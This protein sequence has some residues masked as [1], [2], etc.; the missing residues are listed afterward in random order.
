M[1]LSAYLDRI[2][3]T[4]TP[5]PDRESLKA[6]HRAHHL[7]VPYDALDVQLE[8]AVST[9][10]AFAYEKIVGQRRGGW[11]YEMNGVFG[12]ALGEIGF[13]VTRIAAGANKEVGGELLYGNHLMLLV[14]LPEGPWIADVGF[15]DGPLEP[16]PLAPGPFSQGGFQFALER[17]GGDWWRLRNREGG[18]AKSFDFRLETADE[19]LM[20]GRCEWLRYAP[21]SAYVLTA[22]V[23]RYTPDGY[24]LL[25]G[26]R[27]STVTADGETRRLIDTAEEYVQVLRETFA[28]DLPEA[29]GLW[30]RICARHEQVMADKAPV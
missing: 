9:D 25:R 4:G 19:A 14:R 6:L 8:R 18:G 20:A 29:A 30:P 24:L 13:D 27:L 11:C 28:L 17:P 1:Q 21:E 22:V 15:G 26:R 3:F 10:P 2:G 5:R 23:Q 12:W 16:Y 7:T